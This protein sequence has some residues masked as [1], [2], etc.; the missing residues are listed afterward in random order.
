MSF[1]RI[2]VKNNYE[3]RGDLVLRSYIRALKKVNANLLLDGDDAYIYGVVDKNGTFHELFTKETF[4]YDYYEIIPLDACLDLTL[5]SPK[6]LEKLKLIVEHFIFG[7]DDIDFEVSTIEELAEDR[8]IEFEAYNN[9]LSRINPYNRLND[10]K[11]YNDYDNFFR[12][13]EESEKMIEHDL[14]YTDIDEYEV[15]ENPKRLIRK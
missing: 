13:L 1:A 5:L 11:S 8:A 10:N 6:R 15:L 14:K 12:K 4:K 9:G 2:K 3:K 7:H